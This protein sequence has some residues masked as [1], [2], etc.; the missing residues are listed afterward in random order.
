MVS[1][2][3]TLSELVALVPGVIELLGGD[4]GTP[5]AVSAFGVGGGGVRVTRDGFEVL[6]VEGGVPDLQRI[7]LAGIDQ[8]KLERN[9]GELLIELTSHRYVDGRP[10]S[11]VEAGTGLSLIHI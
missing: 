4:Y 5:A 2:A 10:F 9:G 8:V 1:G 6:P 3:N 7:G 11:V